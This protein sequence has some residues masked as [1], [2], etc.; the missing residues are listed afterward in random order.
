MRRGSLK[1]RLAAAALSVALLAVPAAAHA[2]PIQITSGFIDLYWDGANSGMLLE[3]DGFWLG[4]AD[5]LHLA[6]S[7]GAQHLTIGTPSPAI[8][9]SAERASGCL[10]SMSKASA[11]PC[12]GTSSASAIRAETSTPPSAAGP[13]C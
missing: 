5:N 2:E 7:S 10:P 4:V 6:M 8:H 1:G 9:N 13:R 12:C 11:S 3:G